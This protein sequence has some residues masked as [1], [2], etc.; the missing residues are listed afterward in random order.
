MKLG[1]YDILDRQVESTECKMDQALPNLT[2]ICQTSNYLRG[3]QYGKTN[4]NLS[5]IQFEYGNKLEKTQTEPD[6]LSH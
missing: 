1:L 6:H 3:V 4:L 5:Q 2:S